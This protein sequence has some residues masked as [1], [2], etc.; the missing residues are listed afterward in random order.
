[1]KLLP[2]LLLLFATSAHA[3]TWQCLSPGTM[4]SCAP[5]SPNCSCSQ[6]QQAPPV[7]ATICIPPTVWNGYSCQLP[8]IAP[9][10]VIN[11]QY[12]HPWGH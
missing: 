10:I 12:R 8:Y 3:Q 9:P 6:V 5:G 11:P 7:A 2:F 1:M 4:T